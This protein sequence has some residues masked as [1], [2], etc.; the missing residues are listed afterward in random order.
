MFILT[1]GSMDGYI[2]CM[3]IVDYVNKTIYLHWLEIS[4]NI[5]KFKLR[6][7]DDWEMF[8]K[9]R[10]IGCPKTPA[11]LILLQCSSAFG[12]WSVQFLIFLT[13]L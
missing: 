7:G 10:A 6:D 1:N 3:Y 5:N 11:I 2:K 9:P 8:P 4:T 13:D 12:F